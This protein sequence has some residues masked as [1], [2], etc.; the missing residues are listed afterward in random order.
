MSIV[1]PVY[2]REILVK[3]AIESALAQTY[4]NI[5]VVV[6]D[7]CSTDN[8][9]EVVSSFSSKKI[10]AYKN[11]ENLGPVLNWIRGIELSKG[12]YVKLLFSDDMISNNFIEES[13][14]Q[15]D[16]DIAFVISPIRLLRNG[17]LGREL[18]YLKK[19]YMTGS[20][21]ASFY[22]QFSDLFPVSPGAAL[23]RKKDIENAFIC[24]IPTMRELDPMKNGAGIDLL[25]YF[26]IAS[27]YP[28][29]RISKKSKAIFRDHKGSF[30]VSDNSILHFYYRAMIFYLQYMKINKYSSLFKAFLLKNSNAKNNY[31]EE[32]EMLPAGDFFKYYY[33]FLFIYL[34][35]C[36][37]AN[38]TIRKSQMLFSR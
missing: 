12:E 7:N 9:W 33:P 8:T 5:E 31:K 30:T 21:F 26:S 24:D 35:C 34:D 22:T 37:F 29:I 25:I 20:Y 3:D 1:I 18:P 15:F 6:V 2:N 14:T 16:K 23:F 27:K 17:E 13:L 11:E 38:K 36:R 4:D 28:K 19:E 10:R 32:Y